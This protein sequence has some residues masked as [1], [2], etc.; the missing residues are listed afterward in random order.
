[1]FLLQLYFMYPGI[2]KRLK[3]FFQNNF[4][5]PCVYYFFYKDSFVYW[6][7]SQ[8]NDWSAYQKLWNI[9]RLINF[10][11]FCVCRCFSDQQCPIFVFFFQRALYYYND[12]RYFRRTEGVAWSVKKMSWISRKIKTPVS[13]SFLS[14]KLLERDL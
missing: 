10:N 12:K 1:M 11:L 8:I 13:E 14:V 7:Q 6:N 3:Q 2:C 5:F 9:P 4:P